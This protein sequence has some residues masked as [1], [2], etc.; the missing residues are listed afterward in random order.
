MTLPLRSL[1]KTWKSFKRQPLMHVA[2]VATISVSCLILGAFLLGYRNFENLAAQTNTNVTGT[3]Y[4]K[5]GLNEIEV[6]E[7]RER[8]LSQEKVTRV[9]FKSKNKVADELQD[10]LGASTGE[11]IPGSELF[12][13]LMELE[14]SPESTS[15][16]VATLKSILS[17]DPAITEVDFSDDWLAQ[18]KK[19]RSF[20]NSV[21]WFL[22]VGLVLGCGFIIANFM[23]IRHQSRKEEMEIIQLIGAERGFVLAPF[24]WE[25]LF[26]GILG[27]GLSL[28]VLSALKWVLGDLLVKDW[29]S[30]LGISS[31]AFLSVSQSLLLL[32]LG[33]T[34]ALMGS[35]TVFFRTAEQSR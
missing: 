32:F 31:W 27:A 11:S 18:Y 24:L 14:L 8:L 1:K 29:Q 21:G 12:P 15:Q 30:M 34:M 25:G 2:S 4:L 20:L 10:F 5:D 3:V 16:T 17:K 6:S 13:D 28:V 23:G 33:I 9:V 19:V 35:L 7:L 26:E 22:I